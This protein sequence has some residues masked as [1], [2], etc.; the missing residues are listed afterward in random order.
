MTNDHQPTPLNAVFENALDHIEAAGSRSHPGPVGLPTGFSIL[1]TLT[2]GLLPGTLT[3]IASRPAMGR[4]T[5]I[6]DVLRHTAIANNQPAFLWT[7]EEAA[8]ETAIRVMCAEARVAR[9]HARTGAMDDAAW[10]RLARAVP[11]IAEAPLHIAAPPHLTAA[12]LAEA[13]GEAVQEHH[14]QLIVIDGIQDIRPEQRSDLREREVGDVARAL[15]ALARQHNVPVL[16]TAHLNRGP[17]Q[18]LGNR[19]R[20]DD[21]R[22]SGAITFAADTIVL[23]HRDDYYELESPRAGE[24]DLIVAKHRQGPTATITVAFQ[25]HYGRFV[26]MAP[27]GTPARTQPTPVANLTDLFPKP[28]ENES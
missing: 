8:D 26:D 5:L 11:T 12:Q 3:V 9:H 17:E 20:L 10:Q 19:P 25:G 22:E 4:T 23:L 6:T 21:L 7:L 13:V 28:P 18:R 14:A 15:K 1:D 27:E 16:A 2:G 24:A